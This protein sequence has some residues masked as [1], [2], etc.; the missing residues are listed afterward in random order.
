MRSP[1][2][3]SKKFNT[4]WGREHL[5]EASFYSFLGSTE[6]LLAQLNPQSDQTIPI[7]TILQ[8]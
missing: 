8:T 6:P 3:L 2:G 7:I 5:E 1:T 4:A